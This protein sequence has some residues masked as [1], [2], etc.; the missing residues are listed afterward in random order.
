L[1]Q[2]MSPL[3]ILQ[4]MQA[5]LA[6]ILD[7]GGCGQLAG[8]GCFGDDGVLVLRGVREAGGRL[9]SVNRSVEKKVNECEYTIVIT[10]VRY[11]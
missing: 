4:K 7:I 1:W 9:S 11:V 8:M 2:G 3:I 6:A 5:A 10:E